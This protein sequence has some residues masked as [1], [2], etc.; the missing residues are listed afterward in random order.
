VTLIRTVAAGLLVITATA[1]E[2]AP[3]QVAVSPSDAIALLDCQ[4][5]IGSESVPAEGDSIV[6]DRVALPTSRALQANRTGDPGA[7]LFAKDGLYIRRGAAFDLIV[8]E[9]SRD[10][11][12]INWGF[13]GTVTRH[14]RVPGCR[15]TGTINPIHA[16]DAWLVYAGGYTVPEPTCVSLVVKAGQTEQTVRIG[17]GAA[18]PGQGPPPPPV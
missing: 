17:V 13:P 8:P 14:L 11:L 4:A 7:R 2:L 1:C 9:D 12:T 3:A 15:P 6:L 18:C 16:Q 5:V 10:R